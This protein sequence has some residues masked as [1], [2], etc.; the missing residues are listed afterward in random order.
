L[1]FSMQEPRRAVVAGG[2]EVQ[3]AR[4]LLRAVHSVYQPEK[5]VLGNR[6]AVEEFARTLPAKDGALLYVCTGNACQAP[7]SDP[8]EV[9]K[10]LE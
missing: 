3:H 8:K 9:G 7:T 6:G 4:E 10:L 2:P 5:I 1:D